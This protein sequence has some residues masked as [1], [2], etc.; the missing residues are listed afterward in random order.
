MRTE[1][2]LT[3]LAGHIPGSIETFR[4]GY[5]IIDEDRCLNYN[6][7]STECHN[8]RNSC[9]R[10]CWDETGQT[11]PER[12]NSCGLCLSVCPVD[13]I[14]VEGLPV[15]AWKEATERTEGTLH[16]SCRRYG[17]GPWSCL[18]FLNARDLVALAWP[19]AVQGRDVYVYSSNCQECRAPVSESLEREMAR[20]NRFLA[21]LGSGRVLQGE[22]PPV[23]E[24]ENMAMDRRS[25]FTSLFST[26]VETARNVMWPEADAAPLPKARWRSEVLQGRSGVELVENQEVFPTLEIAPGC[27]ACALCA[28]I[29]PMQAISGIENET[30]V[31]LWHAPLLCTGCGLCIAHCP[32]NAITLASEGKAVKQLLRTAEFPHCNE[33]GQP[34]KPAGQQLTCFECLLK[35]RQ[36]IFGP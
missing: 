21:R 19:T 1:R 2:Y 11:L 15:S 12:C 32:V 34:F 24:K 8:C 30:G 18:G 6:Y 10:G 28:K 26:G 31:E 3:F 7:K 16:L 35:G 9:P 22:Q 5:F 23:S 27:I 36:S 14:G 17:T 33:C 4:M 29:C 25:F 13:A 20:A